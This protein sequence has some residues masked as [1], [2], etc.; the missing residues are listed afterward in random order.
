M[1]C[2]TRGLRKVKPFPLERHHVLQVADALLCDCQVRPAVRFGLLR[3]FRPVRVCR[4]EYKDSV[5]LTLLHPL[6]FELSLGDPSVEG[7]TATR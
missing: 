7:G 1:S 6:H 4:Q 5:D 2:W 3:R